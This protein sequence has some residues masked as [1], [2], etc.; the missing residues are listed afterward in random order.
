MENGGWQKLENVLACYM[1]NAVDA[2]FDGDKFPGSFGSTRN[3]FGDFGIDYWTLR[4][5]SLQLFIENPYFSGIVKRI[6]RNE[7]FTGIMPEATPIGSIIWPDLTPAEREKLA[8]EYSENMTEGFA[9][10]GADYNVFD[11][12]KQLTFGEFQNQV[13]L[14]SILCGDGIIVSRVNQQ[15]R[16]PCWDWINSNHIKTNPEYRPK[17]KNRG[18]TRRGA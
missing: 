14:E 18:G 2:L 9:L 1:L 12:K 8:V 17:G 3:Y 7:I 6:I 15:T 13:R 11:Y 10:Y 5:R 4:R 16:L